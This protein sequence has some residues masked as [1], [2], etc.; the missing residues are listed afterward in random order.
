MALVLCGIPAIRLL[1]FRHFL[2]ILPCRCI[3]VP[4]NSIISV[5][6][7]TWDDWTLQACLY[8]Y[9]RIA[10]T[11]TMGESYYLQGKTEA[12]QPVGY[13]KVDLTL[14]RYVLYRVR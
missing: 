10:L 6:P 7:Y 14:E 8:R 4:D 13:Q 1:L 9:H 11:R 2:S 3:L 5:T 12:R